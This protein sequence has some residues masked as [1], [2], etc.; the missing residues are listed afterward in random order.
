MTGPEVGRRSR[1]RG[2]ENARG[3]GRDRRGEGGRVRL[4]LRGML[5][6]G[7]VGAGRA[8][9]VVVEEVVDQVGRNRDQVGKKEAEGQGPPHAGNREVAGSSN[10]VVHDAAILPDFG[11]PG[12]YPM[13]PG[14]S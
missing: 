4:K 3:L 7:E 13:V 11:N 10:P 2:N 12:T 5:A 6:L 14:G 1:E 9:V 8:A